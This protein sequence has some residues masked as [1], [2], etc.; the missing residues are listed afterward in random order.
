MAVN[1]DTITKLQNGSRVAVIGGG[2]SGAFSSYFLHQIAGRVG[3][4]IEVDIYEPRD[5]V[6]TGPK[7]CNMCGGIVSESLL[8]HLAAEGINLPAAVIQRRLDSYHLHMDVGSVRIKTPELEKRIA[9]VH[10]GS[11]PRGLTDP[12]DGFDAHIL[13]LARDQGANVIRERVTGVTLNGGRPTLKTASGQSAPYDLLVV[14]SGVNTALLKLFE[15]QDTGYRRPKMVQASICEFRLGRWMI[16]RHLGN[17]MHVFLLNIPRLEFAALI[18]KGEYVTL[19]L[20][21]DDIDKELMLSFLDA[22]EVKAVMPPDWKLPDDYCHCS[23]KMPVA[24]AVKPYGDRIVFVGDCGTSRLYKDGIG[25]AYRMAKAM[26]RTAFFHGV[27]EEAFHKHYR[28]ACRAMINDNR[29]GKFVFWVTGFIQHFKFLRR[30][31][32]RMASREQLIKGAKP[33]MSTV[34]WDT[35]TGSASYMS[36]LK[37]TLHPAY[38]GRLGAD[39]AAAV[40]QPKNDGSGGRSEMTTNVTGFMGKKYHDGEVIFHQGERGD[41]MYVVQEGEVELVQRQADKEFCLMTMKKRD[42]F[43]ENVIFNSNPVRQATARAVG[44]IYV[45]TLEKDMLLTRLHEDPSLAFTLLQSMS[46]RI[47]NLESTVVRMSSAGYSVPTG[48]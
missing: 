1:P 3:A 26:S 27:S 48:D 17:A 12:L 16:E 39:I 13:G 4:D 38:M 25:A 23:P 10:R 2:P 43:G 45:L 5:F 47:Q 30:A 11:G 29:I 7:S 40:V 18:P 41:C 37:R 6:C 36:V 28:P 22:P 21:G 35:F 32:W 33:R 8:M 20:L 46:Q 14:A 42:I 34:L 24:A 44:D 15:K 31:V 19:V 9:A